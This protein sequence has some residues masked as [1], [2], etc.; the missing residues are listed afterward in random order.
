MPY[1][2]GS[3]PTG[4]TALKTVYLIHPDLNGGGGGSVT[5]TA[6]EYIGF[7]AAVA[8][9]SAALSA[10]T[11]SDLTVAW[12]E[13]AG[14]CAFTSAG[15]KEW[16]IT[17]WPGRGF[18]GFKFPV[19]SYRPTGSTPAGALYFDGLSVESIDAATTHEGRPSGDGYSLIKGQILNLKGFV[20]IGNLRTSMNIK[21]GAG[22]VMD[23]MA[24]KGVITCQPGGDATAWS[25][26]NM[27]GKIT[28]AE[29][30]GYS[31]KGVESFMGAEVWTVDLKVQL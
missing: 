23:W 10:A 4:Y 11:S 13:S 3:L 8:S 9:L 16:F 2:Y 17:S 30:L 19:D 14:R 22:S 31:S 1:L 24:Y 25:V 26:S 18:F 7:A 29:L 21:P 6:G 27:D 20:K 15:D 12:S 28:D 5:F